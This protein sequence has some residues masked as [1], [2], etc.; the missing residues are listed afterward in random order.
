MK[1]ISINGKGALLRVFALLLLCGAVAALLDVNT[2]MSASA[3]AVRATP[4]VATDMPLTPPPGFKP[5]MK[6]DLSQLVGR[7]PS[8]KVETLTLPAPLC[9]AIQ[10]AQLGASCQILHYWAEANHLSLPQ[11]TLTASSSVAAS[12]Y[13]YWWASDMICSSTGFGCAAWSLHLT[14]DGV[15]NGT[16]VYQWDEGCTPGGGGFLTVVDWCGFLH[17]GG[18]W[19]TNGMQFG[20]NG[21]VC[22]ISI[23][24]V[25][26]ICFNHG[27]RRWIND[28]GN[29]GGLYTW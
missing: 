6:T 10:K 1:K 2:P 5:A 29:P 21:H 27:I 14:M 15:A 25:G 18:G 22:T 8:V 3:A 23:G 4:T 19:P 16:R 7:D 17:N 12:S 13:W 11:G 20:L 9:A 24:P 28:W 26:G